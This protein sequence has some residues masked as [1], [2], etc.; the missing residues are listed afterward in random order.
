LL[1]DEIGARH[2]DLSAYSKDLG[3]IVSK[4]EEMDT[5]IIDLEA[6]KMKISSELKAAEGV[7]ILDG[8]YAHDV[9]P[10]NMTLIVFVF[11]KAPWVLAEVLQGRGYSEAKV[12][13]NVEAEIMG[14]CTA[15][16]IETHKPRKV[17]EIDTTTATAEQSLQKMLRRI[18]GKAACD[19]IVDWL[20]HPKTTE[21][22]KRSVHHSEMP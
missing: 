5:W 8:H 15:E 16:A 10:P 2:I 9:A 3:L 22:I 6:L 13:E 4:D 20:S 11:R 14:V 7:V 21:L 19:E 17:C 18:Q 1:A 12:W